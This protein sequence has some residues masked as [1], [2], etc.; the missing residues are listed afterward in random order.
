MGDLPMT[1][2]HQPPGPPAWPD[3]QPY[4]PLNN[5]GAVPPPPPPKPV[6][7]RVAIAV[8]GL[9]VA[10]FAVTGFA[11]PGFL[12]HHDDPRP[13]AAAAPDSTSAR[14]TA[15]TTSAAAKTTIH[16]GSPEQLDAAK[17]LITKF[18]DALNHDDAKAAG[19]L[20]CPE[21]SSILGGQ[22]IVA[23][24]APTNLSVT[25]AEPEWEGAGYIGVKVS[26]TTNQR[27]VGGEI[28]AWQPLTRPELCVRRLDLKW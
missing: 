15:P 3:N 9:A 2:S 7:R 11:A 16:M 25:D 6:G 19:Q 20:A 26:G 12:L 22:L 1:H 13:A 18:V 23:V 28:L 8:T 17:K 21:S 5:P 4:R 10:T 14:P 27:Q 24:E